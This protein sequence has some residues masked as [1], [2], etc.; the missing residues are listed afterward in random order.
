MAAVTEGRQLCC[1]CATPGSRTWNA[2]TRRGILRI[3]RHDTPAGPAAAPALLAFGRVPSG[4][5]V[6]DPA[7]DIPAAK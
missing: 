2:M 5:A 6:A 7:W 1:G 3:Y 4:E